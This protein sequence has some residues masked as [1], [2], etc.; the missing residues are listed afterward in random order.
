MAFAFDEDGNP[1]FV[2]TSAPRAL[3]TEGVRRV[4]D[5]FASAAT[6]ATKAGFDGVEIRG[7]PMA[8]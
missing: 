3:E 5:D 2:Q 6:N 4:V 1:G 8:I 7:A